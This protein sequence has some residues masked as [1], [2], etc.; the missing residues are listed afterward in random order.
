M[1]I[2]RSVATGGP[3]ICLTHVLYLQTAT[4]PQ[5]GKQRRV[6]RGMPVK[7][8]SITYGLNFYFKRFTCKSNS[9]SGLPVK[10]ISITYSLNI[11]FKRFTGEYIT[12][13][14]KLK[15]HK[16]NYGANASSARRCTQC[17]YSLVYTHKKI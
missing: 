6:I 13:A 10:L 4:I 17:K 2:K 1:Q 8:I 7:L 16:H 9:S 12:P 5:W 15:H 3:I 11:Y 14:V